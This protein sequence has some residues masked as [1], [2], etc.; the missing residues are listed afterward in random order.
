MTE[1]IPFMTL[2]Q[3]ERNKDMAAYMEH[4][5]TS[6][7]AA[8]E[9]LNERMSEGR[10]DSMVLVYAWLDDEGEGCTTRFW[11]VPT[12]ER[13]A[14]VSMQSQVAVAEIQDGARDS[15]MEIGGDEE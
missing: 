9:R 6:Y 5:T 10:V 8:M 1:V 14:L 4:F 13:A 2:K 15:E 7:N 3:R 11:C 12:L